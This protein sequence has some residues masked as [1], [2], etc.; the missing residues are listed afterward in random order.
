MTKGYQGW[1]H[2][3]LVKYSNTSSTRNQV[4]GQVICIFTNQVEVLK[5]KVKDKVKDKDSQDVSSTSSYK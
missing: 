4:Q 3:H 1:G 5:D 2:V